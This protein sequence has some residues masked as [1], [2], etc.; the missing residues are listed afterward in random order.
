MYKSLDYVFETGTSFNVMMN[1]LALP[2]PYVTGICDQYPHSGHLPESTYRTPWIRGNVVSSCKLF[3]NDSVLDDL[4]KNN[5]QVFSTPESYCSYMTFSQ[6]QMKLYQA[7]ILIPL[8][9]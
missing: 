4:R 8:M 1:L 3:L 5:K 9:S 7:L 6:E 2:T